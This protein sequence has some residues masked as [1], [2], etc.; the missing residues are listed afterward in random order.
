MLRMDDTIISRLINEPL[1]P[2]VSSD[3]TAW[4]DLHDP[5]P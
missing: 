2:G 3:S 5:L 1:P 4:G